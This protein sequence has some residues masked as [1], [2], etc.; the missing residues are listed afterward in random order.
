M[1]AIHAVS[2]TLIEAMSQLQQDCDKLL[3]QKELAA[4]ANNAQA[5]AA[6]VANN[7][8]VQA[9]E[10]QLEQAQ[11]QLDAVARCT[12]VAGDCTRMLGA[13]EKS[14]IKLYK[15]AHQLRLPEYKALEHRGRSEAASMESKPEM[16]REKLR[17]ISNL[18][19]QVEA[20][21]QQLAAQDESTFVRGIHYTCAIQ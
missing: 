8:Q 3:L 10:T 12:T 20:Y 14:C 16:F 9:V 7:A 2:R 11:A 17:P 13:A 21:A 15:K 19:R 1:W 5:D 4:A 6:A 18:Y